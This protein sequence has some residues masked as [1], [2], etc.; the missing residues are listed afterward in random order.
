MPITFEDIVRESKVSKATVSRV[1]N[2]RANVAEKTRRKVLSAV[3]KLKYDPLLNM[4]LARRARTNTL[5]LVLPVEVVSPDRMDVYFYRAMTAFK[6]AG[7]DLG[8]NGSFFYMDELEKKVDAGL[9]PADAFIFF[10]PQGDWDRVLE[11]LRA[12]DVPCVLVRRST[13]VPHVPVISDD[14]YA[15][16]TLVMAHLHQLGH[17]RIALAGT[18]TLPYV[19]DRWRAYHDYVRTHGLDADPGLEWYLD[20]R[21]SIS[22]EAWLAGL[23]RAPHPPTAVVCGHDLAAT[24]VIKIVSRLGLSV[25][26]DVAVVGYDDDYIAAV[27]HPS[28][29]TVKIPVSEML[30][31]ACALARDMLHDGRAT[32]TN[33]QVDNQLVV[34]ESCGAIK[35][36]TREVEKPPGMSQ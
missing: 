32:H 29:T 21:E 25:P 19:S 1:L 9:R 4:P 12:R 26:G 24:N 34:R 35:E 7:S 14:D 17:R 20:R 30:G 5:G 11:K 31:L 36:Q 3:K 10:C 8:Y 18:T 27:F 6:K 2:N 22:L 16:G 15:G 13:R 28:I 33:I 23:L